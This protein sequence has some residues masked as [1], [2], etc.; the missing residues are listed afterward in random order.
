MLNEIINEITKDLDVSHSPYH[1]NRHVI[2][3]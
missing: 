2:L 3:Q 1:D